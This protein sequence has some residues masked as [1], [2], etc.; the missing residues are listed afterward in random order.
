V[1]GKKRPKR[2]PETAG[3]AQVE[4]PTAASKVHDGNGDRDVTFNE[5]A[6]L[7]DENIRLKRLLAAKLSAE[8]QRLIA[9]LGRFNWKT[10]MYAW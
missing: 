6:A 7:I 3:Q 9:M 1:P 5:L 8:N 10:G 4:P 2:I